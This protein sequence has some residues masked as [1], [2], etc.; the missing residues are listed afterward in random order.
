MVVTYEFI[1]KALKAIARG[2]AIEE[3]E[4]EEKTGFVHKIVKYI[5]SPTG[6]IPARISEAQYLIALGKLKNE[7]IEY[8]KRQADTKKHQTKLS[9]FFG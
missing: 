1:V 4:A 9:K 2:V 6:E 5:R 3:I 8:R 7:E